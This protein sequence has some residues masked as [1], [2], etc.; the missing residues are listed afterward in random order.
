MAP[1]AIDSVT[2]GA[3]LQSQVIG[4]VRLTETTHDAG[5]S[6]ALHSHEHPAITLVLAGSFSESFGSIT[7]SCEPLSLL[8]KPASAEHTNRYGS[9]GSR[10]F[11]IELLPVSLVRLTP[12]AALEDRAPQRAAATLAPL[13]LRICAAFRAGETRLLWECEE[14]ALRIANEG[15]ARLGSTTTCPPRWLQDIEERIRTDCASSHTLSGLA[16]AANVH[17]I[18]LARIFRRHFGT[19]IGKYARRCRIASAVHDLTLPGVRGSDVAHRLGYCDQSHF[20]RAFRAETDVQP[21]AYQRDLSAIRVRPAGHTLMRGR[22]G[23]F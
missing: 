9:S 8:Y 7:H 22:F 21:S 13:A 10:S 11:I 3:L 12:F 6:I 20:G 2:H 5:L 15:A 16:S 1:Y 18:Y 19:S 17:P 4:G 23:S 14:I